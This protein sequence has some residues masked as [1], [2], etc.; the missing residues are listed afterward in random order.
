MGTKTETIVDLSSI[1]E[2]RKPSTDA[3]SVINGADFVALIQAVEIGY[4]A[5]SPQEILTRVRQHYYGAKSYTDGLAFDSL[6]PDAPYLM[7]PLPPAGPVKR[8]LLTTPPLDAAI[9]KSLTAKAN[10]NS[11]GDNPSPYLVDGDK[12]RVDVGHAFLGLDALLHPRTSNPYLSF[13][14]PNIDISSWVADLATAVYW[15][16][17]DGNTPPRPK[18]WN[19]NPNTAF[20][21]YYYMAVPD[22]DVFGDA[23]SFGLHRQ[24][25]LSKLA[26]GGVEDRLSKVLRAYYLGVG[27][28]KPLANRRWRIFCESNQFDYV[29]E[30]EKVKWGNDPKTLTDHLFRI[31][32]CCDLFESGYLGTAVAGVITPLTRIWKQTKNSMARF[33]DWISPLLEA[34]LRRP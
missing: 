21:S 14:I 33:K 3:T 5:D 19:G 25:N 27:A 30:N 12:K 2:A 13:G 7:D 22:E 29:V 24:W 9:F 15:T 23:D 28:A 31:H 26:N 17:S 10:E 6:I 20:D 32:R 11:Q 18:L 1:E 34:E 8:R 16:E 4:P